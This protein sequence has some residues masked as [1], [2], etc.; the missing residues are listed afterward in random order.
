MSDRPFI[1]RGEAP[2]SISASDSEA[3]QDSLDEH[4]ADMPLN[5]RN[6]FLPSSNLYELLASRFSDV[7]RL[8]QHFRCMPEI[9]G[10]EGTA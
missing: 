4:L 6:G 10:P 1:H 5:L 2:V 9:I 8:S 3:V 7:V